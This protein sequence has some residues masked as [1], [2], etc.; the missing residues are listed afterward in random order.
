[1]GGGGNPSGGSPSTTPNALTGFVP[2]GGAITQPIDAAAAF[3]NLSGGASLTY[4]AVVGDDEAALDSVGLMIDAQTGEITG[5]F[6]GTD[7][8][9]VTVTALGEAD[10]V[11]GTAAVTIQ[12]SDPPMV[13]DTPLR[14]R[15]VTSGTQIAPIGTASAFEDPDEGD[16]LRFGATVGNDGA[17]LST[18]GLEIDAESGNITGE[19][20]GAEDVTITVTATDGSGQSVMDSFVVTVAAQ[21]AAPPDRTEVIGEEIAPIDL[22]GLFPASE[23]E[24]PNLVVTFGRNDSGLMFD[25][26]TNRITGTLAGTGDVT[27]T[28]TDG[29]ASQ[30]T[31]VISAVEAVAANP[32]TVTTEAPS[33]P[34]VLTTGVELVASINV[35][36]WFADPDGIG[37]LT[38]TASGLDGIGLM[39]AD[40]EIGG[41]FTGTRDAAI[42]IVAG[43][44]LSS[45]EHT[46]QI[47]ANAAPTKTAEAPSEALVLTTGVALA[48]PINAGAWFEDSNSGQ[49]LTYSLVDPTDLDGTGLNFDAASGGISGTYSGTSSA[50]VT[51]SASDGH[52]SVEHMVD[53]MANNAPT[54]TTDAP[55]EAMI[56]TTGTALASPI[57]AAEWFEDADQ[58][59]TLTYSLTA[60]TD[61]GL[62]IN[63]GSG[64]IGG[65]FSGMSDTSITVRATDGHASVDHTLNITANAAPVAGESLRDM[66]VRT[67]ALVPEINLSDAFT[68]PD[69]EDTLTY[70]AMVGSQSLADANIGLTMTNAGV[71]SGTFTGTANAEV[72]ISAS[73]GRGGTF[74]RSFTFRKFDLG[75]DI[76]G[77]SGD[78]I[79]IPGDRNTSVNLHGGA[80]SDIFYLTTN[81]IGVFYGHNA[82]DYGSDSDFDVIIVPV[83]DNLI[84][85]SAIIIDIGGMNVLSIGLAGGLRVNGFEE[86]RLIDRTLRVTETGTTG[87]DI[88][89]DETGDGVTVNGLVGD[90][91][92]VGN[93]GNDAISGGPGR[94]SIE[95]YGG[96]D[97]L[98]GGSGDDIIL[99]HAGADT[100][101]GGI[102]DDFLNGGSEE[103]TAT[104][105]GNIRDFR[106]TSS[107][108]VT[109]ADANTADGTDEGEDRLLQIE[110][111][112]F[113]DGTEIETDNIKFGSGN[114]GNVNAHSTEASILYGANGG[115]TFT[116]G[117]VA[118]IFQFLTAADS[119]SAAQTTIMGFNQ[120]QGDRIALGQEIGAV[121]VAESGGNTVMTNS[122]TF[123]LVI[124]G[125]G[126]N[127]AENTHYYFI[128]T[129]AQSSAIRGNEKQEIVAQVVDEPRS[130][131][132]GL[133]TLN[134]ENPVIVD[135][136][137]D[138]DDSGSAYEYPRDDRDA[139]F[140]P[141]AAESQPDLD[142]AHAAAGEC[143]DHLFSSMY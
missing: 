8:A 113:G 60:G 30:V 14:D 140:I 110:K 7:G 130:D 62:T 117:S 123:S 114:S 29:G 33:E 6:T 67:G 133:P 85:I 81:S 116:G 32:P 21:G 92:I 18:I 103:D 48:S 131:V 73:D 3:G 77:G 16:T 28:V 49:T 43:D 45:A 83:Q 93:S 86:I 25:T 143:G 128:G 38:F 13:S 47:T 118:D 58:G 105:G 119:T 134:E 126:L 90:D 94:D 63:A 101:S 70:S 141:A 76:I 84:S 95:G 53:I 109:V 12:R 71:I 72:D 100:I 64:E 99:G 57:S 97:S 40:G 9:V 75:A 59:Q 87:H 31:F 102:G 88:I 39:F 56:L 108:L 20:T 42:R 52:A 112:R 139:A 17:A 10:A 79:I 124:Q 27:V 129:P 80:G 15:T 120:S 66:F 51:V 121:T 115:Y 35:R 125:N 69:S 61:L 54:K 36:S 65:T 5:N 1:M 111:L 22:N 106:F 138:G 89:F 50:S 104:Y 74:G 34:L 55:S 78:D 4:R 11:R 68:D 96:M 127:L 2:G 26:S 46:L 91:V 137:V 82:S 135:F 23:G 24:T 37:T 132:V 44:G 142:I 107:G 41:T 122:T 19:I 136:S 98:I